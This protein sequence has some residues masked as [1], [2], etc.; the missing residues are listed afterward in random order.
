MNS[1]RIFIPFNAKNNEIFR[2]E[3]A[4][5][6]RNSLRQKVRGD[7]HIEVKVIPTA[8]YYLPLF[9]LVIITFGVYIAILVYFQE[10]GFFP[11][12]SL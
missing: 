12:I 5:K 10:T 4:F 7:L 2:F 1:F 6:T 3:G 8:Y 9:L 11:L